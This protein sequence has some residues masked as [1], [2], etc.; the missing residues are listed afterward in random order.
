M[1]DKDKSMREA[2]E[3]WFA[4]M[5]VHNPEIYKWGAL[6]IC[7]QDA[8]QAGLSAR[9]PEGWKLV[10]VAWRYKDTRGYWRYVGYKADYSPPL[11][12]KPEK[13]YAAPDCGGKMKEGGK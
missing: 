2:Y 4:N 8:W 7:W 13:L 12:L 3:K 9:I 5:A 11:S 1:T 6:W 10:P